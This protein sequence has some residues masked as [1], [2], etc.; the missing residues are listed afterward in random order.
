MAVGLRLTSRRASAE[1]P[2]SRTE[3]GPRP[4]MRRQRRRAADTKA[5]SSAGRATSVSRHPRPPAART[6][7][8]PRTAVTNLAGR[9]TR[10]MDDSINHH[11][12]CEFDTSPTSTQEKVSVVGSRDARAPS[13]VAPARSTGICNSLGMAARDR[14]S[15]SSA[16]S[17]RARPASSLV[18]QTG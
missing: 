4:T 11:Q 3:I 1:P 18:E 9:R 10:A 13:R 6:A 2:S 15:R 16:G 12:C 14:T 5:W 17:G 7:R 8:L